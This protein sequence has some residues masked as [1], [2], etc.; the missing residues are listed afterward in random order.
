MAKI[1]AIREQPGY[2]DRAVDYF[3]SKREIARQIY[4]ASITESLHTESPEPRWYL[5][6][7]DSDIIGSY[8]LIE[9]DFM[10]RKDLTPWLFA[11]YVEKNKSQQ[12][13][14]GQLLKH[15]RS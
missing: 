5:M 4:E 9:N 7:E 13:L 15:A 3:S 14:G 12:G 1:I 8:G 2:L 6:L 10:V 11:L